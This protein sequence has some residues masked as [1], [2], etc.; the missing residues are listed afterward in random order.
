M[1]MY[2][3]CVIIISITKRVKERG[4]KFALCGYLCIALLVF[5]IDYSLSFIKFYCR[6]SAK[7]KGKVEV[8][9]GSIYDLYVGEVPVRE[10]TCPGP[11]PL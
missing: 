10:D 9:V 6:V 4:D 2:K 7:I 1:E 3:E 8:N 11:S 5:A